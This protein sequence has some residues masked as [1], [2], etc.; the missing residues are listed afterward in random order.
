MCA[1]AQAGPA[2]GV[3]GQG[4]GAQAGEPAEP[5]V[6]PRRAPLRPHRRP[7]PACAD[8]RGARRRENNG[9]DPTIALVP[10]SAHVWGDPGASQASS[11]AGAPPPPGPP[12]SRP[13]SPPRG[14][15]APGPAAWGGAAQ[16]PRRPGGG[17]LRPDEFP[18]L[19]GGEGGDSS[20][21][22]SDGWHERS[23][24]DPPAPGAARA[25]GPPRGGYDGH[26]AHASPPRPPRHA[27]GGRAERWGGGDAPDPGFG[28]GAAPHFAGGCGPC[29]DRACC[30][31]GLGPSQA[32]WTDGAASQVLGLWAAAA[33]AAPAPAAAAAAG[34]PAAAT[35]AAT[36]AAL[37]SAGRRALR[38]GG[39]AA[40]R[41]LPAAAPARPRAAAACGRRAADAAAAAAAAADRCAHGAPAVLSLCAGRAPLAAPAARLSSRR[42]SMVQARARGRT[43]MRRWARRG[44]RARRA[45]RPLAARPWV[46]RAPPTQ[47]RLL[48][49]A[50]AH[51]RKHVRGPL[52]LAAFEHSRQPAGS[53]S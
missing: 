43:A 38:G 16:A 24:W 40:R 22:G 28:G 15:P 12:R 18:S 32:Q 10:R 47:L 25:N 14:A 19:G 41:R 33:A 42:A 50:P 29:A 39:G 6:R 48:R 46:H 26:G 13:H 23:P 53:H 52:A 17:G 1:R 2:H 21:L 36:A 11:D 45:A 37:R 51:L 34:G 7:P 20:S 3:A 8:A 4:D 27:G 9:L 35:A 5:E 30:V 44:R 31:H 49:C